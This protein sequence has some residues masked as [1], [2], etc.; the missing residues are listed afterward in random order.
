MSVHLAIDIGASSGRHIL[1]SVR[2]GKLELEEIHRFKNGFK[3]K[4]DHLCWDIDALFE[5]IL[6]G[7][8]KCKA[9]GKTPASIG[10]D[11]W[12][13]DFVLLD[14]NGR[15]IGDAVAYRDSRTDGM[16][17]ALNEYIGDLEL[18]S[19]TGISKLMFN[20]IYQFMALQRQQPDLLG[21]AGGFLMLP[22]YL[23]YLL[24]GSR[25]H[26]YTNATTT[27]MVNA[28]TKDW[29]Y[30]LIER[31]KL[32]ESLFGEISP[33]GTRL[34]RLLPEIRQRVGFDCDVILPCT[35]DTASAVASAPIDNESVYISSGTWS[36]MGVELEKPICSE[37]S[38]RSSLSNEGGYEYRFR[39]LKNIMGM[40]IIQSIRDDYIEDYGENYSFDDLCN[41]AKACAGFPSVINVNEHRF[42]AP[43]KMVDEIIA[44]C[45]DTG[46]QTPGSIGELIYCAYNS[47]AVS[48]AQTINKIEFITNRKYDKIRIVG[49]GCQNAYLN[50]LTAAACGRKVTAGPVEATAIGNILVQMISAG[51]LRNI[52]EARA[53]SAKSFPPIV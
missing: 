6:V 21:A 40:W 38:M 28:G 39:Y 9:A 42:L 24:T 19:R 15:M 11:T 41:L 8:E 25:M 43:P 1:G 14:K 20:T 45:K 22:C 26:E 12:G 52:A 5:E 7:A 4:G 18:Y 31:I 50:K 10:I 47:L 51:A 13:V 29:D 35:H 3:K 33:P 34:G 53:L 2:D 30:E 36:L 23:S 16:D 17:E 46:Q 49:G 48:Y 27:A 37:A 32:P 44:A